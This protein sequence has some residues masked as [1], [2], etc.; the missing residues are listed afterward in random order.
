MK[1]IK[2][3]KIE[4]K[5]ECSYCG[6]EFLFDYNDIVGLGYTTPVRAVV[7][8]NVVCCP[9]CKIQIPIKLKQKERDEVEDE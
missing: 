6:C 5:R 2:A 7:T 8:K 9:I 1:I 3:P 4:L